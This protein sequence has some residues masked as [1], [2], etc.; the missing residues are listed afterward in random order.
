MENLS[1]WKPGGPQ[2]ITISILSVYWKEPTM[3]TIAIFSVYWKEP[4]MITISILSVYWKEPTK[5]K[6]ETTKTDPNCS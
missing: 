4:T 6:I 1:C 3:I 2:M 5:H